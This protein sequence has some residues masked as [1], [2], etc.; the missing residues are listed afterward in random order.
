MWNIGHI[1]QEGNRNDANILKMTRIQSPTSI[2]RL[3]VQRLRRQ[4]TSDT[5]PET[6]IYLDCQERKTQSHSHRIFL[7]LCR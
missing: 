2:R 4:K 7:T 6:R 1:A 5:L 3:P